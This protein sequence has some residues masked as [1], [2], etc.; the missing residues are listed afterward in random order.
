MNEK[1][2]QRLK[3]GQLSSLVDLGMNHLLNIPLN[4]IVS[5]DLMAEQVGAAMQ[6]AVAG[7]QTQQWLT[8]LLNDG[9]ALAPGGTI[10]THLDPNAVNPFKTLLGKPVSID[11]DLVQRMM[12]HEAIEDI[13]RAVLVDVL[14]SFSKRLRSVAGATPKGMSRGFGALRGIRDKALNASPIAAFAQQIEGQLEKRVTEHVDRSI[15]GIISLAAQRIAHPSSQQAQADLRVEA[16]NQLLD[17]EMS[18]FQGLIQELDPSSVVD[19]MAASIR[20][21]VAKEDFKDVILG[22]VVQAYSLIGDKTA[23]TILEE[24]GLGEDWRR[25]AQEQV[26]SLGMD[27]LDTDSFQDWLAETLA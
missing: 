26:V 25:E 5:P 4:R 18:V 27:L 13:F 14:D 12:S 1:V 24:S 19:A 21:F 23:A 17:T 16:F 2:I 20:T 15:S 22:V 9:L 7:D 6:Q 11:L 10:L 8:Q 3:D